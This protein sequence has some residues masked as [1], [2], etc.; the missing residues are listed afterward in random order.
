MILSSGNLLSYALHTNA[1]ILPST[2]VS[3]RKRYNQPLLPRQK[4]IL[5]SPS[6]TIKNTQKS[7]IIVYKFDVESKHFTLVFPTL[8]T[9]IPS[10]VIPT[11]S[12]EMLDQHKY[13]KKY[14]YKQNGHDKYETSKQLEMSAKSSTA[15]YIKFLIMQQKWVWKRY[16]LSNLDALWFH[17]Q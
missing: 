11:L 4:M 9:S 10:V 3:P 15:N 1:S 7:F 13:I 5:L 2:P 8:L 6:I 16:C 14:S 12:S 17:V